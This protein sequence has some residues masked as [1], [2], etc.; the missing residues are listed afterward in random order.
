[1]KKLILTS[2]SLVAGIFL[3]AV[4]GAYALTTPTNL[5]ASTISPTSINL[6][7]TAVSGASGYSIYR[8]STSAPIATTTAISW[9]NSGLTPATAN[10]YYVAAYSATT[11]SVLSDAAI[12]TTTADTVAPTTPGNLISQTLS[13]TAIK[14]SWT[15]STDNIGI[16]KYNVYRNNSLIATTSSLNYT[17]SG[18]TASTTYRYKLS[19]VDTSGLESTKTATVTATTLITPDTTA[20]TTPGNLTAQTLSTT[21]IKLSWTASTDNIGIA[22]YNVYRNNSLIAQTSSLTYTDGSL[23]ASTT[24]KYN[25]SA[26]D[27]SSLESTKTATVTAT[28]LIT[29]D[30]VAPSAPSNLT[31]SAL[32]TT[33]I[34]LNWTAATDN[35]GIANYEVYR[36]NLY[37]GATSDLTY[38]NTGLTANTTYK[39]NLIAVDF[40]NLESVKTATTSVKT[41]KKDNGT[42]ISGVV[43]EMKNG[44]DGKLINRRANQVVKII[45]YSNA[46]F[47]VKNL[48]N[49]TAT[50][51]GAKAY[52]WGNKDVNKDGKKDIVYSFRSIVMKDLMMGDT[53][54]TFKV[55]A[56]GGAIITKDFAINVK[57]APKRPIVKKI[58]KK[59]EQKIE[60]KI[61]KVDKKIEKFQ[62]KLNNGIDK[63]Q[64]RLEN[65]QNI[66]H[67]T[68]PVISTTTKTNIHKSN[69]K[70]NEEQNKSKKDDKKGSKFG[71][72]RNGKK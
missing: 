72:S 61:E 62:D 24:Y 42:T 49:N 65:L 11:T 12:A 18:L 69:I 58:V 43:V 52:N 26:V 45:V 14:L 6:T 71:N 23:T 63:F 67:N 48:K 57:N 53:K 31:G 34:K 25:L 40:S 21:A 20:P 39:Y 3:F 4:S 28:T 37:I 22:K 55:E 27:T 70:K 54:A 66:L 59:I 35:I 10:T 7:W 16:A 33:S 1:M 32:S 36:D 13:T 46:N 29:P 47:S 64:N 19:A 5:V 51:G 50:F 17:N 56:K 8:N 9:L 44:K 15:A 60:K 38:T 68:I 30:T 41:L 2:F